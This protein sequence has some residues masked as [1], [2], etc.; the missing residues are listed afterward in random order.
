MYNKI[1]KLWYKNI[2]I[3]KTYNKASYSTYES[4]VIVQ[5]YLVVQ[6]RYGLKLVKYRKIVANID[7]YQLLEILHAKGYKEISYY[8]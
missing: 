3:G 6:K 1:K 7:Y 8:M 4:P 2:T 5:T